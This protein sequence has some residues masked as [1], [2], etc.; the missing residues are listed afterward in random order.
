MHVSYLGG[1]KGTYGLKS[2][3]Q[4]VKSSGD[5]VYEVLNATGA[6]QANFEKTDSSTRHDLLVEIYKNGKLLTS[7]STGASYGKVALEADVTTGVAKTPI[8]SASPAGAS[9]TSAANTT[10]KTTTKTTTSA[11]AKVT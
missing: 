7:G 1:Y 2:D 9:T 6:I 4:T 10:V 11:T 8:T 5:R 3:L